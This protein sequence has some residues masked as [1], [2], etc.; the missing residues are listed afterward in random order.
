MEIPLTPQMVY[1]NKHKTEPEFR[2]RCNTY[3][4]NSY[5]NNVMKERE[6][7]RARYY[8]RRGLEVPPRKV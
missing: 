3:R 5:N 7:A 4:V 6:S 1:Y 2:E 8:T